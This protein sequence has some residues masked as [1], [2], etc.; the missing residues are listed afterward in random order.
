MSDGSLSKGFSDYLVALAAEG[1]LVRDFDPG[2]VVE[3]LFVLLVEFR[4]ATP[5]WFA[6]IVD[7][8][9]VRVPEMAGAVFGSG[10]TM[11]G[12]VG[13]VVVGES[14]V[15]KVEIDLLKCVM[16]NLLKFNLLSGFP[17]HT[18]WWLVVVCLLEV[19]GEVRFPDVG[20][21]VAGGADVFVHRASSQTMRGEGAEGFEGG[22]VGGRGKEA[23]KVNFLP[24][25]EDSFMLPVVLERC[26]NDVNA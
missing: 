8:G 26:G 4:H 7:G 12:R 17:F 24:F 21:D 16:V 14:W 22:N 3:E 15:T 6:S 11:L 19:S 25:D 13:V 5:P 2:C 18:A 1:G 10:P 23:S 9:G 20:N